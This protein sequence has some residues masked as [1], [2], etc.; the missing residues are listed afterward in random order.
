MN[1]NFTLLDAFVLVAYLGGTTAL[2]L[3]IGRNQANAKDYFV[4]NRAI[5]WWAVLFSVVASETSALTFISIPGLAYLGNLGFLQVVAGYII[6]RI[7][8]AYTLLPRYYEGQLVTAYALLEQRFG[9]ATRRF[10]SIVFMVTRAMADAV[11]VF[12]T[13]IPVA[14]I[15]GSAVPREY[16]MPAAILILGLLTVVYTYRGGMKAVVWTELVQAGVYLLGGTSALILLGRSVDGGWSAI[17]S[18]AANADKL[19]AIDWYTGLDRPHTVF[20]GLIGGA[21]LSMASHGAD[22]LIVQRLLSSRS[23]RDAQRALIGSGFVVF[24]QFTLFLMIGVGLWVFYGG[25]TFATPD[26]IFPTFIVDRMPPGLLGLILAAIVAATMSTHSG[27]INSLAAATT[28]DIYLPLSKRSADDPETLRVGKLFALMWGVGLTLGALLFREQGTPVV[29]VALGIASF[30]Y[31]AL[32]GG[33]FL[34]IFWRRAVQRDAIT[35][36][37]VGI[38]AMAFVVFARQLS[39]AYPALTDTLGPLARIA[40][41]WY[42]LIGTTVTLAT[43]VLSSYMHEDVRTGTIGN[44]K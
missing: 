42:V 4:A 37:S 5:P 16:A 27:A 3:Y 24:A 11:R 2:G 41:P 44:T 34:G 13:A 21:F 38:F 1:Q 30:T 15:L 36:M 40:W 12:A 28:H 10:T 19:M 31:G 33:F 43:G 7:V 20:A 25:R 23:L 17:L 22:Q 6:G 8:I 35:G 39:A 18:A 32:L 26:S 29:V 14:L 9:L